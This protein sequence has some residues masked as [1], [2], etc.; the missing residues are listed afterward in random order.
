[1]L[2]WLITAAME[3]KSRIVIVWIITATT[4]I[5][6]LPHSIAGN[7]E[8]LF[9]LFISAEIGFMDYILFIINAI[10]G[11]ILGGAIFVGL[12]KYG[13]VTRGVK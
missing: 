12:L 10:I 3:T 8:V 2:A 6:H 1:M 4:G 11:N 13:H 9:G 5:L 7:G